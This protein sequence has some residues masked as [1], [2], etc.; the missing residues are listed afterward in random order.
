MFVRNILS[1]LSN[2]ISISYKGISKGRA[3]EELAKELE[4][5]MDEVICIGDGG[6]DIEMLKIAWISVAMKNG[7][8]EVKELSDY[9]TETNNKSGVAKAI[10]KLVLGELN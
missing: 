6:N 5:S 3:I 4:I 8:K 1:F 2:V 7:L 9:I 10:K